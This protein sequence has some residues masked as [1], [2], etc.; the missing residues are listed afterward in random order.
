MSM[1]SICPTV[2]LLH[3]CHSHLLL[4]VELFSMNLM[5]DVCKFLLHLRPLPWLLQLFFFKTHCSTHFSSANDFEWVAWLLLL[6]C[7]GFQ[8][9]NIFICCPLYS[10]V[11]LIV[12]PRVFELNR[13][14]VVV[15]SFLE[16]FFLIISQGRPWSFSV[17][18]V[19]LMLNV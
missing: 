19:I 11:L 16:F 3:Y 6:C 2:D 13:W 9:G 10:K 5:A 7:V 12:L 15:L 17:I 8:S 14:E 18:Q 4:L 1:R